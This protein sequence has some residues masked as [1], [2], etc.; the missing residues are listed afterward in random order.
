[1]SKLLTRDRTNRPVGAHDVE[2]H[3]LIL[4]EERRARTTI[5]LIASASIGHSEM[6]ALA[7]SVLGDLTTEGYPG[8]RFHPGCQVMDRI[9]ELARTR[10]CAA[11]NASF[12]NVQAHS[13]STANQAA[14]V[15]LAKPG[16]RVLS[17]ALKAGGHLSHGSHVSQTSQWFEFSHYD[18]DP[19]G[20]LDYERIQEKAQEIQPAV[21]ICGASSYP[22]QID[23]ERFGSIAREVGAA[24]IADISHISGLV[25]AGQHPS[26][27]PHADIVTTSTYK[28]L[29]GPRGGLILGGSN[30]TDPVTLRRRVDNAVFPGLQG[31]PDAASIAAKAWA[32][33]HITSLDFI[34][35]VTRIVDLAR[36]AAD[37]LTQRG[38]K[39]ITGGTDTHMVLVDVAA[40]GL[41]GYEV[42]KC[43]ETAGILTN[44]NTIP[45]D[46]RP[47]SRPSGIRLG[48]N[49]IAQLGATSA[50]TSQIADMVAD[51]MDALQQT[52]ES[53]LERLIGDTRKNAARLME[54]LWLNS[55]DYQTSTRSPQ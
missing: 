43:L 35:T 49:S 32:F 55:P 24:L 48:L 19:E 54:R 23:F 36:T 52:S 16:A 20:I 38:Y 2:L 25:V 13:G 11:F 6:R 27:I 22:R 28:Q 9:E 39:V 44:R 40:S 53:R 5:P 45:H 21:I 26:P 10:A 41:C 18:V 33:G 8:A 4:E 50:Q 37:R 46:S 29:A 42:E 14:I 3:R 12:A 34:E 1:M 31:T 51:I 17:M 15:A 7:G 30:L 47:T